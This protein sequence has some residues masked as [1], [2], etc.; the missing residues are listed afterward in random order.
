MQVSKINVPDY[1]KSSDFYRNLESDDDFLIEDEK[2]M[3]MTDDINSLKD[4]KSYMKTA[5]F[6]GL[7]LKENISKSAIDFINNNLDESIGIL[8]KYNNSKKILQDVKNSEYTIECLFL[9]PENSGLFIEISCHFNHLTVWKINIPSDGVYSLFK[10][11]S[12]AIKNNKKYEYDIYIYSN[13]KGVIG[14]KIYNYTQC[15][16]ENNEISFKYG[17]SSGKIHNDEDE[18]I[19]NKELNIPINKFNIEKICKKLEIYNKEYLNIKN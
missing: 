12:N 5:D 3:K 15:F 7:D 1:L 2:Y 6:W 4:L 17:I 13:M 11:L 8:S 18:I 14:R 10:G 16:F 9:N 19:F